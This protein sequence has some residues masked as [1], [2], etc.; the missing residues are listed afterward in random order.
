MSKEVEIECEIR[1]VT[2]KAVQI[3]DG[4]NTVW[5]PKSQITDWSGSE[6]LD[7]NVES[8]FVPLWLATERGLI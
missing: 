1:A 3:Y 2:E 6:N 7:S 8:I 5:L 4:K